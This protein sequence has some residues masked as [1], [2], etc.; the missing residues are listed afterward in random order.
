MKRKKGL[1]RMWRSI[2]LR[3]RVNLIFASL[4]ALWLAADAVH[5]LL[6]ASGRTRAETQ[7]AMRLTKDFVETTLARS[8]GAQEPGA[9]KT[10]VDSLQH[11]RHVR[12]G[13]GDPSLASSILNEANKE[14]E[15]PRWFRAL[16]GAPA[17]TAVISVAVKNDGVQSIILVAD[18]ADEIDEVWFEARD[19]ALVGGLLALAAV[20]VSSLLVGR[21]VRPL[22][23]AGATL[24]KLESGDYSARAEGDGPPEIRNLNAKIN[25]LGETLDGLNCANDGLMERVFEAHDE[26]RQLIARELHDE[27]GPHL[28]ALRASAAVLAKTVGDHHAARAAVSA[29]EAQVGE[30][31]GQ[32]RR[33][34]A[35]LRPAALAELG[36]IEALEALVAHWRRA[37][38]K[39]A[40]TLEVDP[41]VEGLSERASLMAYRFVQEAMTNA[42]RHAGA[43]R[44]EASLKFET[45]VG[46]PSLRDPALA[47]LIIRVADDGKG[48]QGEAEPGMGLVGMRD[49]VRLMGG[50]VSIEQPQAGGVVIEARF[51]TARPASQRE[52]FPANS[53]AQ[54]RRFSN[55]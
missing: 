24:A 47:G 54:L 42:F 7:S 9:V 18:P 16:V 39:M 2:S 14:S 25:S 21:A 27:F 55:H 38:S 51:A 37:E 44:I 33:I 48:F 49:R 19:H 36:L 5:V 20:W 52:Y 4:F 15:A 46:A 35:D 6:Q 11:L 26:E 32:N 12:A 22:G 3:N 41:R 28:F 53:G 40:V 31:Q 13:I 50:S 1:E 34:L 23:V 43:T 8:P 30:L 29:I 17:E 45:P 10:L